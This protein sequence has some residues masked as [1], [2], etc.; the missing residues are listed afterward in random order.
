[1]VFGSRCDTMANYADGP[2]WVVCYNG[3]WSYT[4]TDPSPSCYGLY[5]ADASAD[6]SSGCEYSGGT[7]ASPGADTGAD[8]ATTT[9]SSPVVVMEPTGKVVK[10]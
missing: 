3:E 1:M 8:T 7:D 4:T 6:T 9:D 5:D 10:P 2:G